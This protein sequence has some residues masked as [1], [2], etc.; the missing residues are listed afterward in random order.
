METWK[1]LPK[2]R[3]SHLFEVSDKGNVRKTSTKRLCSQHIRNGYKA[4]NFYD[5]STKKKNT[6][7]V[8]RLVLLAFD[9]EHQRRYVNHK[10]GDKTD[11]RLEN[12]EWVTA[13]E[14]TAHALRTKI[15]KSHP[16]KVKQYTRD[17]D[18]IATFDSII[19]A[20]AKT[21]ANDRHISA[22]C[23]GKRKTTGGFVWKYEIKEENVL[24]CDGKIIEGFPNYMITKEGKVYSKRYK[25][26]LI[27]KKL[28]SGYR[29]VKL[30]NNGVYKDVYVRKL[31]REYYPLCSSVLTHTGKSGE[32]SGENSEVCATLR[33]SR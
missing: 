33:Q 29:C 3:Y 27:P 12:L 7:N 14:N 25:R 21:G 9:T 11:N 20:A 26:Y 22:V 6:Y 30:C 13:K 5:P 1:P 15:T 32:G 8:H 24:S 18:Y 10:N 23:R 4:T 31:V 17:G 28:P 2:E 19:E 16:K